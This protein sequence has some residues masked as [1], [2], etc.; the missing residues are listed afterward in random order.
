MVHD[1]M[2]HFPVTIYNL[3]GSKNIYLNPRIC[4][5]L[6]EY[7]TLLKTDGLSVMCWEY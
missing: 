3:S 6:P 5:L 2:W 4:N 1:L 7:G